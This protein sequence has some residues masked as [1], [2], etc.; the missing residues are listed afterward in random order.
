[1]APK[2]AIFGVF[3]VGEKGVR[4]TVGLRMTF[5]TPALSGARTAAIVWG[6]T[7][8]LEDSAGH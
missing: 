1:M 6:R 3:G 8:F 5:Q 2:N 7:Q 4:K